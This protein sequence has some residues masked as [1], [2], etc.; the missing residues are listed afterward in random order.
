[1]R[2]FVL[3]YL[4]AGADV[5]RTL[6]LRP[7]ISPVGGYAGLATRR[8][9]RPKPAF[10]GRELRSTGCGAQPRKMLYRMSIEP[11][12]TG[13]QP[14]PMKVPV[15]MPSAFSATARNRLGRP[16]SMPCPMAASSRNDDFASQ[17][18]EESNQRDIRAPGRRVFIDAMQRRKHP[19]LKVGALFC[20][21]DI[22]MNAGDLV[23]RQV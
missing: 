8:E 2:E 16:R 13:L 7:R 14:P 18:G 19:R 9:G 12:I 17:M 1:M 23:S 15:T 5:E 22:Q 10:I 4:T 11:D 21:L 20:V 3:R 6:H